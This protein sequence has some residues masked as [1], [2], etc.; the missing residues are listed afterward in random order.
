MN[1]RMPFNIKAH[2]ADIDLL[3][4]LCPPYP[5]PCPNMV[6]SSRGKA[7]IST[8]KSSCIKQIRIHY[9][10]YIRDS[11]HLI[12]VKNMKG[13]NLRSGDM[14]GDHNLH[15]PSMLLIGGSGFPYSICIKSIGEQTKC[16]DSF[17]YNIK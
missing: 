14:S 13:F 17:T 1:H 6:N 11:R 10:H 8:G 15:G 4:K 3:Y 7:Q 9:R 12:C 16:L 2:V 5:I